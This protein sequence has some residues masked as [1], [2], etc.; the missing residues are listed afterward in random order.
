MNSHEFRWSRLPQMRE[1]VWPALAT[2]LALSLSSACIWVI[3]N[4]AQRGAD[5]MDQYAM[6]IIAPLSWSLPFV[7]WSMLMIKRQQFKDRVPVLAVDD[8]GISTKDWRGKPLTFLWSEITF[9]R[10]QRGPKDEIFFRAGKISGSSSL[11]DLDRNPDEI[12]D[13]MNR[14]SRFAS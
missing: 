13:I 5:P 4:P 2:L 8:R 6:W 14:C 12:I 10:V 9:E 11:N 1:H 7:F 3:I